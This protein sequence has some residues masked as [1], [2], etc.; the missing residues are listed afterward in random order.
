MINETIDITHI[1]N[2]KTESFVY[3]SVYSTYSRLYLIVKT[4]FLELDN[5][6]I[7][8]FNAKDKSFKIL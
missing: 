4:V 8:L 3:F 6:S 5:K 2:D 1:Y 7:L